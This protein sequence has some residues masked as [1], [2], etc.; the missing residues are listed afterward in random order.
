MWW[1]FTEKKNEVMQALH[2]MAHATNIDEFQSTLPKI[3]APGLNIMY[4][5]AEGNVAWWASAQLYKNANKASTK[6]IMT[7]STDLNAPE[8]FLEFS[9]N[10]QA[11]NPPWKYVYSANNQPDSIAEVQYPGYYLPENRAIRIVDLLDVKNDW[12][13]EEVSTMTTDVTSTVNPIVLSN[14]IP[15]IEREQLTETQL[16]ALGILE[17][18]QGEYTLG[19]VAPLLYHRWMYLFLKHTFKDELAEEMFKQLLDTHMLKRMI[20]P[21]ASKTESVW[22]DDIRTQEI[23]ESKQQIVNKAY[24]EAIAS[25]EKDFGSEIGS[26]TMGQGTYLGTSA[27]NRHDRGLTFLF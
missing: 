3:H 14:L 26:W 8:R 12:T 17:T 7:D 6:M 21:M 10:P 19:N 27:P 25:I 13:K 18:W 24:I 22:W 20:A 4:G 23:K 5:D 16:T 11:I 9:E 15:L 1:I 2:G